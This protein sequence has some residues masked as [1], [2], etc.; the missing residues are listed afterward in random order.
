MGYN[1]FYE[2]VNIICEK[3]RN[4]IDERK[5]I[6]II[7]SS[8]CDGIISASI[9]ISSIWK[10]GGKA[11]TR[12]ENN[13]TLESIDQLKKEDHE[14]YLFTDI[15]TGFT[16]L[17]N[18]LFSKNWAIFD[19]KK[20]SFSEVTID[21][22]DAV[23]NPW[24]YDI[25]GRNEISSGGI[26]YFVVKNL[27]KKFSDLS[28]LAI[29]SALGDSQDVG[30]KKSLIGLNKEI[31]D[32]SEKNGVIRTDIDLLLSFNES[33]PIHESIANT[34]VP[35]LPGLTC[36]VTKCLE[37]LKKTNIPL[38]KNGRWRTI[39]DTMQ[40]EKFLIIETIKEFLS[41]KING[42][43]EK[44]E[45]ILIGY[46]YFLPTEQYGS[47]VYEARR[48][49]DLLNSCALSKKTG[50]GTSICLGERSGA[51]REAMTDEQ[52]FKNSSHKLVSKILKEKWRFADKGSHVI[53]NADGIIESDYGGYLTRL[54]TSYYQYNNNKIIIMKTA[55]DEDNSKYLLGSF[56]ENIDVEQMA[57]ELSD[58]IDGIKITFSNRDGQMI[59]NPFQED[60]MM[61]IILKQFKIPP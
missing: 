53:I 22:N 54:L 21:D 20:L 40:E 13:L 46:N 4:L 55:I 60:S 6:L 59:I 29:I 3:V 45:T 8:S 25:D 28:S 42:N 36:D 1:E 51:L 16:E 43:F 19:H 5:D 49:S 50:L 34:F 2:N 38:K 58:K 17:F 12:F 56:H 31:L 57:K 18:R 26:S 15:G 48:F 41:T 9:L 52:G 61:S 14:F 11:S 47:P 37:L 27:D 35:Y 7:S 23:L 39:A 33:L 30:D 10:S 32:F 24:K 44:I